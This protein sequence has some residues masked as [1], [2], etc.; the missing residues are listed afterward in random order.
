MIRYEQYNLIFTV[1]SVK[2][3]S[4]MKNLRL[5]LVE[6]IHNLPIFHPKR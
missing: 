2:N 3:K 1:I 5:N 4:S 6:I